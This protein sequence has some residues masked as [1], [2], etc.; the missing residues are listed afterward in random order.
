M[1]VKWKGETAV[2]LDCLFCVGRVCIF[3]RRANKHPG[4]DPAVWLNLILARHL[5]WGE[6]T[7][8]LVGIWKTSNRLRASPGTEQLEIAYR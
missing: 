2:V 8:Q 6:T 4:G 3:K 1:A 7:S 5:V